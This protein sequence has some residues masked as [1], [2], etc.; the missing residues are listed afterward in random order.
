ME[1]PRCLDQNKIALVELRGR[2]KE[3]LSGCEH[4][5][6]AS[7]LLHHFSKFANE[8]QVLC[9]FGGVAPYLKVSLLSN[10]AQF[11]HGAEDSYPVPG[12][13]HVSQGIQG[14]FHGSRTGIVA[15]I[16]YDHAAR[17]ALHF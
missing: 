13:V 12:A 7:P 8:D 10:I 2:T 4:L 17:A 1:A 9:A 3:L 11:Q 16:N 6:S 5:T 15:V 14:S